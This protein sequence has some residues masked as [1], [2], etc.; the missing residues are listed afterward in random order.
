MTLVQKYE[1]ANRQPSSLFQ[2]VRLRSQ[3]GFYL[4]SVLKKQTSSPS[5]RSLI[6]LHMKKFFTPTVF[7]TYK[8]AFYAHGGA[9]TSSKFSVEIW[10]GYQF[11]NFKSKYQNVYLSDQIKQFL[12]Q[13]QK[14][15]FDRTFEFTSVMTNPPEILKFKEPLFKLLISARDDQDLGNDVFSMHNLNFVLNVRFVVAA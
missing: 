6:E 8:L 15:D 3:D 4:V 7:F 2:I 13:I 11:L 5:K 14:L 12:M 10:L 9:P 1:V